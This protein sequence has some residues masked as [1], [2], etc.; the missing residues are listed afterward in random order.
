[1]AIQINKIE[2]AT[3][4]FPDGRKIPVEKYIN[5]PIS[6]ESVLDE[7]HGTA[8]IL[9]T[10]MRQ[11]DFDQYGVK[12]DEQFKVNIPIEIKFVG[13]KTLI[14][15]IIARDTAEMA[16]KDGWET[17]SHNV[18]F[19]DELKKLEQEPVDNLTFKNTIP[20]VY[21]EDIEATWYTKNAS[22]KYVFWTTALAEAETNGWTPPPI[23][24]VF[25]KG[26][27]QI[28]DNA[29]SF[30]SSKSNSVNLYILTELTLIITTP[31]GEQKKYSSS[32]E[33]SGETYKDTIHSINLSVDG[34]YNL[35]FLQRWWYQS[36]TTSY[37]STTQQ[38]ETRTTNITYQTQV[39]T[40]IYVGELNNA[41]FQPYTIKTV[42]DRILDVT[43][44]RTANGVNK[45]T[46]RN[47]AEEYALEESPEFTFTG[48]HLFEVM[49][50]I[51]SYKKMFPALYK[52]EIFFRP[53]WNG[54]M[55][56]S[57]D[58]PP[59]TKAIL[60]SAVD[61]YCTAIDSYVENMVCINDTNVGTVVEPYKNGFISAR[62]NSSSE[63]S[64]ST[65]VIPTHSAIYQPIALNIGETDGVEVGDIMAYV[66]EQEDYEALSDTSAAYPYSKGYALKYARFSNNYTE[67]AHRIKTSD[68]IADAL[69][70]P[71][72]ANI[73][74]ATTNGKVGD[75]GESLKTLLSAFIGTDTAAPFAD[76]LFQP[77]YIPVVNA[78][79][80]QYKPMMS[81]EDEEA[82][83]FYNQQSEVVDSE[84]FGEHVKG[85][86]QKLGNHT[87]IRVY[88]FD[89]VDDVPTVGTLIDEK[90]VYN[91]AMTIFENHV[92]VTLCLVDYAELSTYIGVKNEIKTSDI[93]STKWSNRFINW[94]EFLIF[95][96]EA[97]TG[98]TLSIT[99]D[100]L[101]DVVTF[102]ESKPLTCAMF[103][104]YSE[105]GDSIMNA[106]APIKHL[107]LGNSI[108]FQWEMLDNFAVGYKS[109]KAPDG[110]T[111]AWTGTK[112][113]RAQRAVRYCD[114]FGRMEK[115]DFQLLKTGP[116][117]DNAGWL[118]TEEDLDWTVDESKEKITFR[119]K[120]KYPCYV[121]VWFQGPIIDPYGWGVPSL[122][123]EPNQ[124]SASMD[125]GWA[126]DETQFNGAHIYDGS[127][128]TD[129]VQKTKIATL[130]ARYIRAKIAHEYPQKPSR[131]S[132]YPSSWNSDEEKRP[133]FQLYDWL[134]KKNSAEALKFA[135]QYHFRQTWREFVIGSGM[136]NFCALVGGSCSQLQMFI[137]TLPINRFERHVNLGDT[138]NYLV[139]DDL[140]SFTVDEDNKRVEITLPSSVNDYIDVTKSWGLVGIDKN[141]NR[142]LIFGENK[143]AKNEAFLTTIYLV[144][145]QKNNEPQA[146]ATYK[147]SLADTTAHESN[148][149]YSV[150]VGDD[151]YGQS[152][153]F[154]FPRGTEI[155]IKNSHVRGFYF[156]LDGAS[157]WIGYKK[158][159]TF[160]LTKDMEYYVWDTYVNPTDPMPM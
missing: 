33:T 28:S 123:L 72:L 101:A 86:V 76:L 99:K 19:V 149:L 9:M 122:I 113:D 70:K 129:A 103:T 42:I 116:T 82:T 32:L 6:W 35:V 64:E 11:S 17:W 24:G 3:M 84:A 7:T 96:H 14:R 56:T 148:V 43:P 13:Q 90:S 77:T 158:S 156:V 61:Q 20:R 125:W 8:K 115:L 51:A 130:A 36:N 134:I 29:T 63:I 71:A 93:S 38:M 159:F 151:F 73:L 124:T 145:M 135:A 144:A 137:S 102:T 131:L 59:P 143:N 118:I 34:E 121:M 30:K 142:Q 48:K 49:L 12:V 154:E 112:Y 67:L 132:F 80:R 160:K 109:E 25:Q 46:F 62:S 57:A 127:Y 27:F 126:A 105:S 1:M 75:A 97:Y 47:N 120:N 140:P 153:D 26:L 52:N 91:V 83:L 69:T 78:R 74:G 150:Y 107:A 60:N 41:A 119:L 89:R 88:R 55:L 147:L 94:E 87:E 40:W 68:V 138:Y 81:A 114:S 95:T 18:E 117:P 22:S 16:R 157:T 155:T 110:A 65:A 152:G 66:Y 79:V 92:D 50:D 146:R 98:N 141:G 44:T 15:M 108:Y 111:S 23:K 58:L 128:E 4:E 2:S 106:F 39:E 37:N 54:E 45:Y 104:T 5:Q 136:S 139:L 21:D 53:F 100:A 10:D 85:L 31:S 133:A